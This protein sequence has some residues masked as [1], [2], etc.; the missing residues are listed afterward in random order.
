[1]LIQRPKE[2]KKIHY[3]DTARSASYA[4]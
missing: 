1:M 2:I 4:R 3:R